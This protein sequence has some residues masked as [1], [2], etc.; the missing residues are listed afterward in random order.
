VTTCKAGGLILFVHLRTAFEPVEHRHED[1]AKQ[2]RENLNELFVLE[3]TQIV[4]CFSSYESF[5]DV[6]YFLSLVLL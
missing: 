2:R 3:P 4:F 5:F 6:S 1:L